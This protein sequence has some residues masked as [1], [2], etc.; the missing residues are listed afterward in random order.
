MAAVQATEVD[1][2]LHQS[3]W[4]HKMLY[5]DRPWKCENFNKNIFIKKTKYEYGGRLDIKMYNNCE[6]PNFIS[7]PP[8][9]YWGASFTTFH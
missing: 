8:E 4:D 6:T 2:K 5:A 9:M 1:A 3:A 7:W